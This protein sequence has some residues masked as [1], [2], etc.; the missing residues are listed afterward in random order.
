MKTTEE[1]ED[2]S[3]LS[4]SQ[5]EAE[6]ELLMLVDGLLVMD[7]YNDC[8]AGVMERFGQDP[9]VCY[10][11]EKV[12]DRHMEAGMDRA[13]AQEFF[14]F[15]QIGAWVGDQTPCFLTRAPARLE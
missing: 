14:E 12:L 6:E 3:A 15:N 8:I 2:S 9:I 13:E 4:S 7:G 5:A 10:D 11:K 1:K